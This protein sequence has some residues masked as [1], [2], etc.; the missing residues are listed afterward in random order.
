MPSLASLQG[1]CEGGKGVAWK[2]ALGHSGGQPAD[3]ER[4]SGSSSTCCWLKWQ[5]MWLKPLKSLVWG[6]EIQPQPLLLAQ[7]ASEC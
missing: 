6:Q 4:H 2:M 1:V 3:K 5:G 7:V